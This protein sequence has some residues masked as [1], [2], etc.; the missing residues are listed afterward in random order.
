MLVKPAHGRAIRDPGTMK[1]VPDE[2][3][4]VDPQDFFW[5]RALA[6]RDL[7]EAEPAASAEN[8]LPPESELDDPAAAET[9]HLE[10]SAA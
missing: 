4:E 8:H 3:L 5:L 6:D 1:L 2:G 10:G 7:V 9:A